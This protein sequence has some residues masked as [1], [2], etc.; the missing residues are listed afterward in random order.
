MGSS[1]IRTARDRAACR[2][3]DR[4]RGV[5]VLHFAFASDSRE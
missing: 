2:I 3:D 1:R 4:Q 5:A